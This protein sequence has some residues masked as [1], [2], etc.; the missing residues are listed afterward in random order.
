MKKI[1]AIL[2]LILSVLFFG[3]FANALETTEGMKKDYETFKQEMSIELQKLDAKIDQLKE[4]SK[5]KAD[6]A[7]TKAIAEL[8][9]S[10]DQLREDMN[11]LEQ[12]TESSWKKMKKKMAASID[13]LNKKTQKL[14]NE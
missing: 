11:K 4:K 2:T 1:R 8:E 13:K 3:I 5:I 10:R 9:Q 6:E 14:L 12:N 7:K